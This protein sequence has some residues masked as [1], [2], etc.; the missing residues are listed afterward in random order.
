M[1]FGDAI[2]GRAL[3]Q[4]ILE[5]DTSGAVGIIDMIRQSKD[6]TG[7]IDARDSS[8]NT[9]L[10][11][12]ALMGNYEIVKA[13]AEAGANVNA[14]GKTGFTALMFAVTYEYTDIVELL[15]EKKADPNA[16][17]IIEGT[18]ITVTARKLA[19]DNA[20]LKALLK[21]YNAVL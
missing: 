17:A 21:D 2:L 8:Y 9:Q 3:R 14:R 16:V 13:L 11:Q 10:M 18:K 1:D 6:A 12:A 19:R 5:G 7:V 15:L 20:L 4:S